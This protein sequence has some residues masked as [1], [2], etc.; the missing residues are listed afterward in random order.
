MIE[1]K[2][3]DR[4]Y[5]EDKWRD[6]LK[7]YSRA[8]ARTGI[9]IERVLGDRFN[10]SLELGGGSC[11]DSIYLSRHGYTCVASDF[12]ADTI[13]ALSDEYATDSLD[14]AV[15]DARQLDFADN[16][17]DLVFHNGLIV[18]FDSTEDVVRILS[19]QA[20]VARKYMLL[21]AHNADNPKLVA[22]FN[23]LGKTDSIYRIRFFSRGDLER[24]ITRAGVQFGRAHWLKFGGPADF[25][26]G[27]VVKGIPNLLQSFAPFLAPRLYPLQPWNRVERLACLLEL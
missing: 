14:F 13:Q 12:S 7:S 6:K 25:L 22:E 18:C 19:E 26:Y 17:F 9:F 15:G 4:E 3:D 21:L 2:L 27:P 1:P 16:E 11:R 8:P 24:L 23:R 10:T 20:R 5:W